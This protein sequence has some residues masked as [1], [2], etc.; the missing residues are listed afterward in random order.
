MTDKTAE[1]EKQVDEGREIAKL[2][3]EVLDN[4]RQIRPA[5]VERIRAFAEAPAV[6]RERTWAELD[7]LCEW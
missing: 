6:H 2:V 5:D 4:L 3:I 7:P 1:L